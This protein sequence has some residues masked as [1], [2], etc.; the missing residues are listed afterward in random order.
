MNGIGAQQNSGQLQPAAIGP[1]SPVFRTT[2]GIGRSVNPEASERRHT[3]DPDAQ[4][5]IRA[6]YPDVWSQRIDK[7]QLR[8]AQRE[9]IAA[10]HL[11]FHQLKIEDDLNVIRTFV[12]KEHLLKNKLA[13]NDRERDDRL[14]TELRGVQRQTRIRAERNK[15][16]LIH[17]PMGMGKTGI[18]M[19]LPFGMVN[20]R[21][22]F[23]APNREI[24]REAVRNA[25]WKSAKCFIRNIRVLSTDS[26]HP[27]IGVIVSANGN[28]ET[29]REL[30]SLEVV[31]AD[32]SCLNQLRDCDFIITTRHRLQNTRGSL[33]QLPRDYFDLIIVDEAHHATSCTYRQI[34]KHFVTAR[35]VYMTGTPHRADGTQLDATLIYR[36]P[37]KQA[38]EERAWK[39]LVVETIE[40]SELIFLASKPC[41]KPIVFNSCEKVRRAGYLKWV[42]NSVARSRATMEWTVERVLQLLREKNRP[43]TS[44]HHQAILQAM[45]L[46][47]AIQLQEI[48]NSHA[49]NGDERFKAIAIGS[50]NIPCYPMQL[51]SSNDLRNFREGGYDAVVHV[52]TLGEGFDLKSL[53][54]CGICRPFASQAPLDQLI[55]RVIRA[56]SPD[57]QGLDPSIDNVAHI[58]VHDALGLGAMIRAF[59]T[60]DRLQLRF[61]GKRGLARGTPQVSQSISNRHV[62]THRL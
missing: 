26:R 6:P 32:P 7:T 35:L 39:Q 18:A 28:P 51:R 37:R 61:R 48:F 15:P 34:R 40:V 53:S 42:R 27:S 44:I 30:A 33:Q 52:G 24:A 17:L 56:F 13:E 10:V 54:I 60:E 31:A 14:E 41:E 8:G 36:C 21:V 45:D 47:H 16:A 43:G 58:V 25:A 3:P 62:R 49:E 1:K 11:H 2:G 23:V 50:R 57:T 12:E 29:M 9:A 38:F 59:V 55:G 19:T 46:Q 22:L 5:C 20:G 4:S